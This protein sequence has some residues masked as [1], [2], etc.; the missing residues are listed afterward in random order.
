M[1]IKMAKYTAKYPSVKKVDIHETVTQ[2][3][4]AS[5]IN[6]SKG[7]SIA[8]AVGSRGIS[9]LAEIVK[10]TV[11]FVIKMGGKPFIVPAMGSHGGATA[12]GQR[13]LLEGYGITSE[14]VGA[15]IISSMKVVELPSD[16]LKTRVFMDQNAYNADGTIVINRI[17]AHTDFHGKVE[18]G[19]IKMCVIGLGKHK[20]ALEIHHHRLYGLKELIAPTAIKVL[21]H[22]NVILGLGI[23]EDAYDKTVSIKAIRPE[24]FFIEE[25]R[26]LKI[27]KA[28]MPKLPLN[29]ID[30]LII[31][32]MGKDISGVGLDTNIIGRMKVGD[33]NEPEYPNITNI[34]ISDLTDASHGN[35]L[36]VGLG[37][38]ITQRLFDKIDL[39]ATYANVITST[40]LERGKIPIIAKTDSEA[41]NFA[42]RTCGP[43]NIEDMKIVR[44]K[45]TLK[46]DEFYA[47]KAAEAAFLVDMEIDKIQAETDILE[48]ND[49]KAF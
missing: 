20:Q 36:G 7:K 35:A 1:N 16:G 49:L 5:N 10:S 15:K 12:A 37:D 45:N 13:E 3:L 8:I 38:I 31:D 48:G 32:Q 21:E 39:Q 29:N 34:V 40:F 26:L 33:N 25:S 18:S 42:I 17:K 11:E 2:E 41:I 23:V 30:I 47:N 6:I 14:Y 46:L 9:N 22:G 28:N 44:I 27:S 24:D 43:I 19:I 4:I